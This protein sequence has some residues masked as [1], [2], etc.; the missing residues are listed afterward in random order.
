MV[1]AFNDPDYNW[2]LGTSLFESLSGLVHL[3]CDFSVDG[4]LQLGC[5]RSS[6]ANLSK[7]MV[8][9]HLLVTAMGSYRT[10][11]RLCTHGSLASSFFP[12]NVLHAKWKDVLADLR[13]MKLN[14]TASGNN[15]S[16]PK[17]NFC[18]DCPEFFWVRTCICSLAIIFPPQSD[19]DTSHFFFSY[20]KSKNKMVS[21]KNISTR[22]LMVDLAG[23]TSTRMLVDHH[24]LL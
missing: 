11:E 16:E 5:R 18:N 12:A 7:K 1:P 4:V 9:S 24:P 21:C 17:W 13:Q 14:Y 22:N 8:W 10:R 15:G 23:L 6:I 19:F 2:E 20:S 3:C